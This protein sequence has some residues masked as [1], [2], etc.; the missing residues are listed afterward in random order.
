VKAINQA[1]NKARARLQAKLP[2]GRYTSRQ[3]EA[4]TDARNRRVRDYLHNASRAVVNWLLSEQL[5]TLIIGYNAGWK[6][7]A[8]LGR[9]TNQTFVQL[10]L[11]RL[12]DMIAYKATVVGI[13]VIIHEESY[14][15]KCSF[16]DGEPVG[17]RQQYVGR[18]IRRGLFRTASGRLVNA[19]VNAAY[20]QI[21]NV[22]PDAFGPGRSGCVVQPGRIAL[23]NRQPAP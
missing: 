13:A 11:R 18:R 17:K 7:R 3:L 19:D 22:A 23:P 5:G 10:P 21:A 15:S 16:F 4:L 20:N 12:A 14:T 2:E 9:R 6:Q 8:N 1:Y